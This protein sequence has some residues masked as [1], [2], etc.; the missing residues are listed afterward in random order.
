VDYV[1]NSEV[2]LDISGA[3]LF[4][5][6]AKGVLVLRFFDRHYNQQKKAGLSLSPACLLSKLCDE[7][8]LDGCHPP[9]SRPEAS[10][11]NDERQKSWPR[12]LHRDADSAQDA[13]ATRETAKKERGRDGS[14][15]LEA[16]AA[17]KLWRRLKPTLLKGNAKRTRSRQ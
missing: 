2:V 7:V 8:V 13:G 14:Q 12:E 4:A 3:P 15:A 1:L 16:C 5:V 6:S 9:K 11:T 10:G 17:W